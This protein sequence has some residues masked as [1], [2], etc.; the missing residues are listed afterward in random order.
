MIV[1]SPTDDT[2]YTANSVASIVAE[3][4]SNKIGELGPGGGVGDFARSIS[5]AAFT[6][7]VEHNA[8]RID[9][10]MERFIKQVFLSLNNLVTFAIKVIPD[11]FHL[12]KN[13]LYVS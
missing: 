4:G 13:M 8:K 11:F 3:T 10:K 6:N 12:Q 7:I 1:A 5:D 2:K 9:N